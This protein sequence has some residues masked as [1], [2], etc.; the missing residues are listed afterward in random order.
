MKRVTITTDGA[1][2]PN[3]GNGGWAAILRCGSAVKEIC[4][5]EPDTTNNRMEMRA[6]IEALNALREPCE[7]ELRTDSMI[8]VHILNRTG[9]KL[10]KRANPSLVQAIVE[11]QA[12]HQVRA[13]WVRGHCGDQDNE[14]A[15][16]LAVEC[17]RALVPAS[18]PLSCLETS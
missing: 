9:K 11:A 13:V 15:D 14:R 12:R 7:V 6:V 10:H 2:S 1:C 18:A 16:L 8:L 5:G 17:S 4:G 3:P